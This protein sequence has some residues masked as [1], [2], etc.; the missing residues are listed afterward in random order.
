MA[1]T[2]YKLGELIEQSDER[3]SDNKFTLDNV[4][5][6]SIQKIFIETKANMEGVSL[7]PYKLVRPDDFAYV[8]VTSRNGEKIT[9]THNTTEDTY[10]VSSSYIVFCVK[11][12][13]LLLSNYLFMYF[14]RTEFD[15]FSR[16]NSWGSA[17][18][19]FSWEDFCDIDID[20]PPIDIQQKY[21]D[22]YNAMISNQQCYE[23]GL[24]DLKLTCDA[25][26]DTLKHKR[27]GVPIGDYITVTDKKNVENKQYRFA[28]LS[29]ENYFI[30]SIA[31]ENNLDFTKYKIVEPGEIGCVLM[32][33]GRDAR[34]TIA[35]NESSECYLISPAYYTFS[36]NGINS[37]YFMLNVNRSEFERRGWFSCDSSARASLPW[38]EFC[39][40]TIPKATEEE[41]EIVGYIY[42]SLLLRTNINNKLKAQIKDICPILIK[43]SIEEARKEA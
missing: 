22:I 18:E 19:T 26:I 21:V 4:K 28:G 5:G 36:I 6:I 9:L 2:K 1:L 20:L 40:L 10:I 24:E 7:T 35:R 12:T 39:N 31:D 23:R 37:D 14:N 11:R 13:D 27:Q 29:M 42:Q 17:R 15:R 43:G 16:F 33:V 32:K 41:Q 38:I 34:I 30:D 3:N 8:T 25:F